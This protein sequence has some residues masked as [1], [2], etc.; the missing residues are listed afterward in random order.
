LFA[1][2]RKIT[3]EYP[4]KSAR[5]G[6]YLSFCAPLPSKYDNAVLGGAN[7]AAW[8]I[9][10]PSNCYTSLGEVKLAMEEEDNDN[11]KDK[12]GMEHGRGLL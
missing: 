4:R 3:T 5:L 9:R 12:E 10:A 8:L 6:V 11:N 1:R 2:L 7:L